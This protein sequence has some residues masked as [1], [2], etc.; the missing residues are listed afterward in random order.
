VKVGKCEGRGGEGGDLIFD[1]GL[2]IFDFGLPIL[3]FG[4]G[5]GEGK[6]EKLKR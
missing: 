5:E 2:S 1:F 6:A 3:D 4:L